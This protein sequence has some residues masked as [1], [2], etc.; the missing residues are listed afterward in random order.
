MNATNLNR[1]RSEK[2]ADSVQR[3]MGSYERELARERVQSA[4]AMGDFV[5]AAA[6]R[7]R[8]AVNSAGIAF[9]K[10]VTLS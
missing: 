8:N 6:A 2:P 9:V 4:L 3:Y 10:A 1:R 7:V 5:L